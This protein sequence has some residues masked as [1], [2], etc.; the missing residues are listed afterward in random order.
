ML[1]NWNINRQG[2]KFD[3]ELTNQGH[4]LSSVYVFSEMLSQASLCACRAYCEV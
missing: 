3:S 1:L 4:F 2:E